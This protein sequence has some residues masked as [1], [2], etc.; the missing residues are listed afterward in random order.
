[1]VRVTPLILAS[2]PKA[3]SLSEVMGSCGIEE[4]PQVMALKYL[5]QNSQTHKRNKG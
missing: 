4:K 1:M 3:H 5:S 2:S